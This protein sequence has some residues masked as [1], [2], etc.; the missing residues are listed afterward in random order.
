MR[1]LENSTEIFIFL[2]TSKYQALRLGNI[3]IIEN[4]SR[5]LLTPAA[6]IMGMSGLPAEMR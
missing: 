1:T 5:G 3:I 6:L 2:P 4:F